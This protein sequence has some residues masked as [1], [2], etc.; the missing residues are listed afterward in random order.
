MMRGEDPVVGFRDGLP[1]VM[2]GVETMC[3]APFLLY[4]GLALLYLYL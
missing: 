1:G 2:E 4:N 3:A